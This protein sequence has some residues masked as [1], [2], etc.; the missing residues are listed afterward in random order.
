MITNTVL[1]LNNNTSVVEKEKYL[2]QFHL[3]PSVIV[4][5]KNLVVCHL[6]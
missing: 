6:Y 2:L 1:V 5:K 3:V 4:K